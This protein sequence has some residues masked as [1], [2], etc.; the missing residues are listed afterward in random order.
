MKSTYLMHH[1]ILG[2]KWGIRRF[3]NSDGTRTS[4]GKKR[5][6]EDGVKE[7]YKT[8][9]RSEKKARI[10]SESRDAEIKRL[11]DETNYLNAVNNNIAAKKRHAELTARGESAVM[12]AFKQSVST[13]AKDSASTMIKKALEDAMKSDADRAIEKNTKE[14]NLL[15]SMNELM[16]EQITYHDYSVQN[17][18]TYKKLKKN[19]MYRDLASTNT[20]KSKSKP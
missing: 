10:A 4:A 2:Q 13:I 12:K 5:Y 16:K 1:G 19:K 17:E 14:T 11:N 20:S 6:D 7:E 18:S 15:K 8:E 3:Q 9:S